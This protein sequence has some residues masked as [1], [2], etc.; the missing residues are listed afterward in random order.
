MTGP[1]ALFKSGIQGSCDHAKSVFEVP[2]IFSQLTKNSIRWS[3]LLPGDGV[4][5]SYTFHIFIDREAREI[6]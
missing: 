1:L 4:G 5:I 2:Y 6:M 3:F